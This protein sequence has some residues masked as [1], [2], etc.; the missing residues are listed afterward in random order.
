MSAEALRTALF[1]LFA[2]LS[3]AL[4]WSVVGNRRLLRAAAAL[5][6]VLGCSAGFYALLG[7]GFLAGVQVLVYVGGIVV[8]LVFLVMLTRT[9]AL[10]EDEPTPWRHNVGVVAALAFFATN[11][12]AL[13]GLPDAPV[14]GPALGGDTR[15]I[16]RALLDVGATGY[17]LPFELVSVLLL[18]ALV[19]GIAVAR[20]VDPASQSAEADHG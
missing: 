8:L 5:M 16:G 2:A 20:K 17:V 3:L 19:G 11:L 12:W 1:W 18:A 7:F 15:A 10:L 14:V 13:A 4:A 9:Q 6:G